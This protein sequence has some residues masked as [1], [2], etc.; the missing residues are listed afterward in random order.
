MALTM[1]GGLMYTPHGFRFIGIVLLAALLIGTT[2]T[3]SVS[4]SPVYAQTIPEPGEPTIVGWFCPNCVG[5]MQNGQTS[6]SCGFSLDGQGGEETPDGG[7][8]GDGSTSRPRPAPTPPKPPAVSAEER[9]QREIYTREQQALLAAFKMPESP[10]TSAPTALDTLDD[11]QAFVASVLPVHLQQA[12]GL[13]EAEWARAR[14]S[15]AELDTLTSQWPIPD[16]DLPRVDNLLSE[17]NSLWAKVTSAPGLTAEERERLRLKLFTMPLPG[18]GPTPMATAA[19]LQ[20]LR[21]PP[22][23]AT[24]ATPI[25][26]VDNPIALALL[27]Q[28]SVDHTAALVELAGE[29]WAGTALGE[30]AGERFGTVLGLAKVAVSAQGDPAEGLAALGDMLV[31]VIPMPQANFAVTGGRIYANVA[32]E[33]MNHFMAQSMQVVGGTMDTDTFWKEFDGELNVFQRAFRTWIGFGS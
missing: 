25:A 2:V 12:S 30:A 18:K 7:Y 24:A 4:I 17:R 10:H 15:Q 16:K 5:L 3:L 13:S 33:T 11:T 20:T 21:T 23:T 1:K 6:C 22:A 28:A 31:G 29:E 9:R 26:H 32:F 19:A 14:S 8:T 27:R